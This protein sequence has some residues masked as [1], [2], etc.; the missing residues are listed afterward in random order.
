[1]SDARFGVM[2]DFCSQRY[3]THFVTALNTLARMGI[4]LSKVDLLAIGIEENYRG[5]VHYQEPA[6]GTLLD[7]HIQIRLKIGASSA[8][9][10]MP[11]QFFYGLHGLTR[12][13]EKWEDRAR[14]FMAPFD[15]AVLKYT[16]K[17]HQESLTYGSGLVERRQLL[18]FLKMFNF[19]VDP[20]IPENELLLL[21]SLLPQYH[22]W[23]GNADFLVAVLS[24]MFPFTF[25]VIENIPGRYTITQDLCT[26]LGRSNSRLG[27]ES[28]LGSSFVEGDSAYRVIIS[29]VPADR[30]AELVKGK[31]LR[32][33]I[34]WM[35]QRCM[36]THFVYEIIIEVNRQA[37]KLGRQS[38]TSRLGYSAFV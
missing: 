17:C 10:Y 29:N 11:Y 33:R 20:S 19:D 32:D 35:I 26:R 34:D 4:D 13:V 12:R 25:R 30:A 8:V 28:L 1:M 18:R 16:A 37:A 9:D 6:P 3:R 31:F 36:P 14:A 21:A 2:P 7:S 22:Y 24:R 38:P 15:S 5:E 27:K 23:S